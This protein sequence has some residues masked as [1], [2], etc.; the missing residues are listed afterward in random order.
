M[1]RVFAV[2]LVAA[3]AMG[4]TACAEPGA[5]AAPP[6]TAEDTCPQA[7]VPLSSLDVI[8][9]VRGY[10]GP[11]TACLSSRAIEAVDDDTAPKLPVTVTDSEGREIEITD[12]DRI[13]P[14]DISGTIA[15]T[16][17]ALGLGD[18]VVGRDASTVFAGTEDLPVVTKTG[19]TLN[20]EAILELA[21]TVV[22]TD[23]TIGPKEVRQQLRDAGIAV[24]VI[25]SDR[26]LDTTDELVTEIA[27]ALGVPSRGEALIARLDASVDE[28]LAE[29]AEVVPADEAD[30]AR[31]LF[32]YVRGSANVYYIFGEDSG[33][34][35]LIDAVGGV[36]VAAEIGWEGMK[37]MTAEALVAAQPDVL[38][39]MTDGLESVGGIDGLIERIPAVAETPAGA[40]RRVIDMADSEI[41]S[42]GPRTA[43]VIGALA[44]ALYAPEPTK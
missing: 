13:L 18:Q 6:A 31:M 8:D 32:L 27:T 34:D 28:T 5:T 41:L 15:S 39:M 25:S 24:V 7:S 26:R 37:P 23:T 1:R 12:V 20:A 21:P 3:L 42:F 9:D 38:V 40:N 10:E 17:F 33:A 35:S 44:R 22:L 30:R 14:I 2:F 11:S 16:V 36:D 29:I 19:H 4:L 43:D